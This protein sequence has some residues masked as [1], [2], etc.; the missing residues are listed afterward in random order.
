MKL[1]K[2]NEEENNFEELNYIGEK[3]EKFK[4]G[5]NER[6]LFLREGKSESVFWRKFKMKWKI[7]KK[8]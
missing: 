8:N 5:L 1:E 6:D 3:E 7:G 2:I 4:T